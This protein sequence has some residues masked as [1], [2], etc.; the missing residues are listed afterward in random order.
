MT[1]AATRLPASLNVAPTRF[2]V[3]MPF[4]N[5]RHVTYLQ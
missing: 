2:R 5:E 1:Y 4:T 3:I